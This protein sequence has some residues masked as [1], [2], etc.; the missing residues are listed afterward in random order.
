MSVSLA[1]T[2]KHTHMYLGLSF[3]RSACFHGEVFKYSE[4][5]GAVNFCFCQ[6]CQVPGT[7][8]GLEG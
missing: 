4:A 5:R 1:F 6:E 7:L 2:T 3:F 8:M